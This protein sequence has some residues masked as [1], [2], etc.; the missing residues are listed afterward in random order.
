MRVLVWGLG[1]LAMVAT[2]LPTDA[3]AQN[4][5]TRDRLEEIEDQL[6]DLQGAVFG[7]DRAGAPVR[8]SGANPDPSQPAA[9][10]N[11]ATADLAVRVGALET[12][13][14][15][16]TGEIERINFQLRQQ[17]EQMQRLISVA[18]PEFEGEDGLGLAAQREVIAATNPNSAGIT[19]GGPIDLVEGGESGGNL[20][21][22][23]NAEAAYSAGRSA[24]LEARYGD[25]ERAFLALVD[26]Y[27]DSNRTGDAKYYLGET[28]L[29]QGDLGAAAR[30]FLDFIR[31]YP[32]NERAAEA[33][34]KLG[35]AFARADKTNEACR[36]W[37]RGLQ[38]YDD[39]DGTLRQRITDMREATCS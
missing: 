23:A 8:F 29:A 26:N 35:Q 3:E 25:A 10:S 20:P 1:A 22:F 34:L 37:Q 11:A 36:V 5:R 27:P 2:Q 32:E 24:L 4:R 17:Q 15:R 30:T 19:G 6:A 13:V 21:E 31:N 18:Y 16:L 7:E 39:M 28:Y 33:H 12:E 14:Q 9:A 38:A